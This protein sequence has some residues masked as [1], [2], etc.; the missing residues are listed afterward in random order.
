MVTSNTYAILLGGTTGLGFATAKKLASKGYNLI[1]IHRTRKS[2]LE[3]FSKFVNETTVDVKVFAIDVTHS[4]KRA[5]CIEELTQTLKENS[6]KVLVH[7][8]AK[9]NLNPIIDAQKTLTTKDYQLTIDAMGISLL[10]WSRA[11]LRAN[12]FAKNAKIMAFTS[13]GSS[14]VIPN[15]AAVSAAKVVLESIIKQIAVEFAPYTVTANAIQAGVTNTASLQ[16]IPGSD[17]LITLAQ[18]H[19][20]YKRLTKVEDVANAVWLLT[21]DEANWIN[22]NIIKVDGGEHLR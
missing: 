20:P 7:S 3:P 22:G 12:L 19:N 9:G 17:N 14:K 2:D 5:Q 1:V 13:E 4:E 16:L 8:I 15:Y 18:K 6:V 11:I 10:E 21:Q